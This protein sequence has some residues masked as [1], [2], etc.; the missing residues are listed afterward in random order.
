ML[1][2]ANGGTVAWRPDRLGGRTGGAEVYRTE[3]IKRRAG[4]L[5]RWTRTDT[6]LGLVNSRIAE[7]AEVRNER[8]RF[9]LEDRRTLEPGRN[10]PQ[11]RHLDHAWASTVHAFQGRTVDT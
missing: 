5:V 11:L 7:V 9:R 6:G 3:A 10:D 8:V 4:D 2:G 1:E